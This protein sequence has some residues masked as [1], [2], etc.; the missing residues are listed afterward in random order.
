MDTLRS[1]LDFSDPQ[2]S[3]AELL[4]LEDWYEDLTGEVP[5][6]VRFMGRHRPDVLKAYR[7]RY[8]SCLKVLPKQSLP[9]TWD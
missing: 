3:P 8:E 9:L 7:D 1:G 5:P 2:L 6:V 4:R